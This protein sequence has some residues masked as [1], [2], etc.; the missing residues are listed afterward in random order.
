MEISDL[1]GLKEPL[2]KLIEVVAQGCGNLSRPFLTRR[3][4][5]ALAYEIRQLAAATHDAKTIGI[6]VE[7]VG[8]EITMI[9]YDDAQL[10]LAERA[11]SREQHQ[12]AR[13][14]QNIEQITAHA[15]EDLTHEESV[16]ESPVDPDWI[17]TFFEAAK[18]VSN[19]EMQLIWARILSG[20][21]KNP[22]SFS[23]RT[24]SLLRNLS[25]AEAKL[26]AQVSRYGIRCDSTTI[27]PYPDFQT[28]FHNILQITYGDLV[29]LMD[30]GLIGAHVNQTYAPPEDIEF[31][32]RKYVVEGKTHF[33]YSAFV[34][35]RSAKELM[36]LMHVEPDQHYIYT[37]LYNIVHQGLRV[38]ELNEK[39]E[40]TREIVQ[41]EIDEIL[42]L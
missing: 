21:V 26:F 32:N 7:R 36:G 12:Q 6:K 23:L 10:S 29:E 38:F 34:Y 40:S 30:A 35:T 5:D 20:E 2:I 9:P 24:L 8:G 11:Q 17:S 4:A 37:I 27:L 41:S 18:H 22:G 33:S 31:G 25:T 28:Y 1:V 14:Q 15:A 19:D 42:K 39:Y 3:N 16:S 13:Q